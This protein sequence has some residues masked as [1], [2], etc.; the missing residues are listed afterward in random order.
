MVYGG[1]VP[2]GLGDINEMSHI[3]EGS[4]RNS[5]DSMYEADGTLTV[6]VSAA[7]LLPQNLKV[8]SCDTGGG[9]RTDVGK[10]MTDV[11]N[12]SISQEPDGLLSVYVPVPVENAKNSVYCDLGNQKPVRVNMFERL[13]FKKKDVDWFL[14]FLTVYF[15]D[16]YKTTREFESR[17]ESKGVSETG[18]QG[19][20]VSTQVNKDSD[21]KHGETGKGKG[22]IDL[23]VSDEDDSPPGSP[24]LW[25]T[26]P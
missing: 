8:E 12:I 5:R 13:G 20:E 10:L 4:I 11:V 21:R 3:M 22:S 9:L 24:E 23:T 18:Q 19:P 26:G 15:K 16:G 14:K 7:V 17:N 6:S 1:K 25:P 2:F